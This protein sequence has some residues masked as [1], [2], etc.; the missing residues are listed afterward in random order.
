VAATKEHAYALDS[1]GWI[2]VYDIRELAT[3]VAFLGKTALNRTLRLDTN[4]SDEAVAFVGPIHAGDYLYAWD[5]WQY[6]N[7]AFGA[8]VPGKSNSR[9]PPDE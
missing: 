8:V 4:Y 9:P 2:Y 5:L 3:N 7:A 1:S 6:E